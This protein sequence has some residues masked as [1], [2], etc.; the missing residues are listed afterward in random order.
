MAGKPAHMPK[1][2]MT[3]DGFIALETWI[4]AIGRGLG[5]AAVHAA[6]QRAF[7]LLTG[8][9]A[10]LSH[11]AAM[12]LADEAVANAQAYRRTLQRAGKKPPAEEDL[13]DIA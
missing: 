8:I 1:F 4:E 5:P 7:T 11:E 3:T 13:D 10:P 2:P 12:A 6:R 9:E